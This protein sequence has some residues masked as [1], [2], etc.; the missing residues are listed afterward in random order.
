MKG[1]VA[2]IAL[3]TVVSAA[4]AE[5]RT[6]SIPSDMFAKYVV[7]Q[8]SGSAEERLIVVRRTS[9]SGIVFSKRVY[10]CQED[11]VHFLGSSL[12]LEG[13]DADQMQWRV[14]SVERG[15]VADDLE[16]VACD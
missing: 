15:S 11:K 5:E 2:L 10:D 3:W 9:M 13:L 1:C 6:I 12:T 16:R 8:K 7:I 14:Q 4:S